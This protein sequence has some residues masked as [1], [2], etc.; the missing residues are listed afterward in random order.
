MINNLKQTLSRLIVNF[1]GWRTNR[2]IVVIESDDWGSIRMPNRDTYDKLLKLGLRVDKDPYCTFDAL[3]SKQD[4]EAIYNVLS[5]FKDKNN[6][7]PIITFNTVVANPDF[8]RIEEN[9]F[10]H[11]I[12]ESF[13]KTLNKYYGDDTFE[14]WLIGIKE[15][16]IKPQFHGREHLYVKKW[17]T[18]LRS[19]FEPTYT[20]FKHNTFGLT[21][22]VDKRT[23]GDYMGA[24][25]SGELSDLKCFE[26]ILE[27]GL[28]IFTQ[29]FGFSSKSFIATTYTWSPY[30]ERKI[31]QLGIKYL[32]GMV[33]QRIPVD[34]DHRFVYKKNNFTGFRSHYGLIYLTRNCYFEP[35]Q[36]PTFDWINDC[37]KRIKIA[38]F[39]GK[40]VI[41]STHRLNF[42][43]TIFRE[44]RENNIKLFKILLKNIT[45]MYPN[46]EFMSSDELGDLIYSEIVKE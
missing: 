26:E 32:Q 31:S 4:L 9:N 20:A 43:G 17:M 6:R 3:E 2:K 39:W 15:G 36:N 28:K 7:N 18:H 22:F 40:P 46:V 41:L 38:F 1:P 8:K 37:L 35:S 24:F 5:E 14:Y 33:H 29:L 34:D 30:L 27:D 25:N 11:Y 10:E 23:P 19:R 13:D 45:Q 16:F 12:Y 21:S 42:I 44:N